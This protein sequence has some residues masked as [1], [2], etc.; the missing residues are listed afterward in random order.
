[1]GTVLRSKGMASLPLVRGDGR[2]LVNH[3]R[4]GSTGAAARLVDFAA[5]FVRKTTATTRPPT[6]AALQ[7][8]AAAR[9][10]SAGER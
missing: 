1:M 2:I 7:A 5:A 9:A 4:R 6:V 10:A 3:F 8:A